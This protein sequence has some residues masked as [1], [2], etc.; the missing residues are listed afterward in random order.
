MR[1]T[2]G[3]ECIERVPPGR[4]PWGPP[5]G[6]RGCRLAAST[7]GTRWQ[8]P[9][10]QPGMAA[11]QGAEHWTAGAVGAEGR[12]QIRPAR[13]PRKAAAEVRLSLVRDARTGCPLS[14]TCYGI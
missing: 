14:L 6:P 7:A 8:A 10:P 1:Y 9:R 3:C 2:L 12:E 13:D 5:S 4:G 11:Q